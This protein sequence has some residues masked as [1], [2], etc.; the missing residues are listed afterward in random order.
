MTTRVS[1][2]E[3]ETPNLAD[4]RSFNVSHAHTR[5]LALVRLF[6]SFVVGYVPAAATND[7]AKHKIE[8]KAAKAPGREKL[9]VTVASERIVEE[10]AG[11]AIEK[12]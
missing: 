9:K 5:T 6:L 8:V 3:R 4:R 7:K 12:K 11:K 1:S 10:Q 2:R